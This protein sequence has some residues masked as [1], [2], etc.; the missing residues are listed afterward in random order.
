MIIRASQENLINYSTPQSVIIEREPNAIVRASSTNRTGVVCTTSRGKTD[1]IIVV[2]SLDE[3]INKCGGYVAGLDGYLFARNH[4]STNGGE[5]AIVRIVTT[6]TATAEASVG[7]GLTSGGVVSG[8]AFD[9]AFESVGTQGNST[10]FTISNSSLSGSFDIRFTNGK[11]QMEYL[12]ADLNP[13]SDRYLELLINQDGNKFIDIS[14][15]TDNVYPL[16]GT[17]SLTGGSN[18]GTPTEDDYVGYE[19]ASGRTGLQLFKEDDSV[20]CVVSAKIGDTINTGLVTHVDDYTLSPRRTIIT[21]AEG[22]SI[23]SAITKAQALNNDKVK[24]VYP[25]VKVRNP[26]NKTNENVSAVPF[27]TALDSAMTYENSASQKQVGNL[28]LGVERKFSPSEINSLTKAQ[29]N[30]IISKKNA[31]IIYASD[32]TT[33]KNPLKIQNA[34]R[35]AK[36]YISLALDGVNRFYLSQD[37]DQDLWKAI[38]DAYEAF[39]QSEWDNGRI[40]RT[41]GSK[42]FSVTIDISNN[43]QNVVQQNQVI[44]EVEVSLKGLSDTIKVYLDSSPD[45]TIINA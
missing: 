27:A 32:Y 26:F 13:N 36:D 14:N 39:F 17:Y 30:P 8:S 16:T 29:V 40:G 12:T 35:K 3:F 42:P 22:T 38:D 5:L 11:Q 24:I 2:G 33:D 23:A 18:G 34:W 7:T 19:T 41:D 6:G 28:V 10:S 1:E 15:I 25:L 21:F 9:I 43:P 37:I 44:A 31:G 4:F 45:K 20:I